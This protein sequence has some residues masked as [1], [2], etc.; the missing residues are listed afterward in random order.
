MS[1][2]VSPPLRWGRNLN[3]LDAQVWTRRVAQYF[4]CLIFISQVGSG[5]YG[6]QTEL[7]ENKALIYF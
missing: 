3:L 4:D 6:V 1:A 7:S 2:L 5:T